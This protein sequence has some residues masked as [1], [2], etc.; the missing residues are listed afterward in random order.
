MEVVIGTFV[1]LC[2]N[3]VYPTGDAYAENG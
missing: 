1:R 3:N 2:V